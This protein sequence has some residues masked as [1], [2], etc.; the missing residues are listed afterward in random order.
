MKEGDDSDGD[1]ISDDLDNC[2]SVPNTDQLDNDLDGIGNVCDIETC[3]EFDNNGDGVLNEGFDVGT[4][5]FVGIGACEAK[6]EKI[7]DGPSSTKCNAA[8][9]QPAADDA[10]CNGIDDNCNGQPDEDFIEQPG[11]S[12]GVGECMNEGII[13]CVGGEP[14]DICVEKPVAD[15]ICDGKDNNCDGA[16][17]EIKFLDSDALSLNC[18]VDASKSEPLSLADCWDLL[19]NPNLTAGDKAYISV[20][21]TIIN[22]IKVCFDSSWEGKPGD[23][24]C[25]PDTKLP[26]GCA[27]E[28]E[29][30][31]SFF[32]K[33]QYIW[34]LYEGAAV[35]ASLH[36]DQ[37]KEPDV[38]SIQVFFTEP[39]K[40]NALYNTV[41]CK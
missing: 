7:C 27:S 34:K 6:G 4:T 39:E 31:I 10:T 35:L 21:D 11:L 41:S 15:E 17:D 8:P 22:G 3:D 38:A 14:K 16:T 28:I 25:S 32:G 30:E 18:Y 33:T 20:D 13:K 9:N 23:P 1:W 2:K 37:T 40:C 5:C 26:I 12:C 19:T 36:F 24:A 29:F